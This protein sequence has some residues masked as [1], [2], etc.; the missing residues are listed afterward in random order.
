MYHIYQ[1]IAL[2]LKARDNYALFTVSLSTFR[3]VHIESAT[4][5][6]RSVSSSPAPLKVGKFKCA[7]IFS[8]GGVSDE[9]L[10]LRGPEGDVAYGFSAI[11]PYTE[12]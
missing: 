10:P 12:L 6:N 5:Q 11:V 7:T 4:N 3:A 9:V 8:S 1:S 2:P